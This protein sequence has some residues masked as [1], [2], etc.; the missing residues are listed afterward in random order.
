MSYL[1]GNIRHLTA[2]LIAANGGELSKEMTYALSDFA[3]VLLT[4]NSYDNFGTDKHK[5]K[6]KRQRRRGDRRKM[7]DDLRARQEEWVEWVTFQDHEENDIYG[8]YEYAGQFFA[9]F[10]GHVEDEDMEA[11]E[12]FLSEQP[13]DEIQYW[14]DYDDYGC[15]EDYYFSL[16]LCSRNLHSMIHSPYCPECGEYIGR[17]HR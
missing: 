2:K 17:S 15:D 8:E 7:G 6:M 10:K 14:A 3:Q 9:G 11:W 12:S 5:A 13:D 4:L 16:N 1:R